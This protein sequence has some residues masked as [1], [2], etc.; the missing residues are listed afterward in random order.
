MEERFFNAFQKHQPS[1]W[2]IHRAS[3]VID[4]GTTIL[5]PDFTFLHND[6]T[7]ALMEI[8][9]FW[10]PEYLEKKLSKLSEAATSN[11]IIAISTALKCSPTK[12]AGLHPSKIVFFKGAL[13]VQDVLAQLDAI[14][15]P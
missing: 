10:T 1:S 11:L 5:I 13:N 15:C 4:L 12:L 9:G 14:R 3:E 8:V 6:G 7:K 2:T